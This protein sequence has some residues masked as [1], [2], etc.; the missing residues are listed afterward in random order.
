MRA[1][2]YTRGSLARPVTSSPPP[3]PPRFKP[4]TFTPPARPG[5]DGP[6]PGPPPP[7]DGPPAKKGRSAMF[8]IALGCT[9]CIVLPIVFMVLLGGAIG[10]GV[11]YMTREPTQV[12]RTQLEE[13]RRGDLDAAHARLSEG[14]RSEL[15]R[16]AFAELVQAH[17]GLH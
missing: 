10:G 8:W 4:P 15:S 12:V 5:V 9:G 11:F 13:L 17:P 14:Y 1:E 7:T 6:P 3:P 2:W 16:T